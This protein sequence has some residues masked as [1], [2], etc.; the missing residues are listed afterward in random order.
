MGFISPIVSVNTSLNDEG[1]SSQI[2]SDLHLSEW[3]T[4]RST[5]VDRQ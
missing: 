1:S 3:L 5:T 2:S 4:D